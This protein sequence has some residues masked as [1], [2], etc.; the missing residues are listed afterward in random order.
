MSK[1]TYFAGCFLQVVGGFLLILGVSL[2]AT[3]SNFVL[4]AILGIAGIGLLAWGRQAVTKRR[5]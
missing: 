4:G 1:P 5:T 2:V 3:G